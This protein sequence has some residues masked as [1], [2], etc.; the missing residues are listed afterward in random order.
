[1]TTGIGNNN[2]WAFWT[3]YSYSTDTATFWVTNNGEVHMR[4]WLYGITKNSW[5]IWTT[6]DRSNRY[7]LEYI[8][9]DWDSNQS[10]MNIKFVFHDYSNG[11][12][13]HYNLPLTGTISGMP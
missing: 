11:Q 2:N 8:F 9:G 7:G 3:G 1:M 12:K 13:F 6:T 4:N 5:A 10:I